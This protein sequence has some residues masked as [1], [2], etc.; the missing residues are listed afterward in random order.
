MASRTLSN[1]L[2]VAPLAIGLAYHGAVKPPSPELA[3]PAAESKSGACALDLASCPV[4]GC[5]DP[6]TDP[7]HALIN[8]LKR[9]T[10]SGTPRILTFDDFQALQDQ[11][12]K[13][14]GQNKPLLQADRNKLKTLQV[15]AG[16]VA[17][18][19]MV[20]MAGYLVGAPHSNKG[21][22]VNCGLAGDPNNDFHIPFAA[23]P[24]ATEFEGI[25]TE[26]IP[27]NRKPGWTLAKLRSLA[28]SDTQVL[29][30]GQLLYDN[31][32]RVNSDPEEEQSGQP[33][34][35]S[36]WEI[37]QVT[38]FAVCEKD[39]CDPAAEADWTPLETYKPATRITRAA[40]PQ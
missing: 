14:V 22:S 12:D 39:Q 16:V 19:D 34:R 15:S 13:L 36:L 35:F 18:G 2:T 8:S 38:A 10:P 37:H 32:H 17:E 3:R 24:K 1:A 40:P 9:R 26:M 20:R 5:A 23:E 7:A 31:M 28:G 29:I 33:R 4:G 11:A 6:K 21:E 25:V 27:Q 30:T